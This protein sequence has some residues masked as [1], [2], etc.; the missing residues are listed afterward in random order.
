MKIGNGPIILPWDFSEVSE[1]ALLHAVSI[2]KKTGNEKLALFHAVRHTRQKDRV[3]SKLEE[4]AKAASEQH[5]MEV[6]AFVRIDHVPSSI[7]IGR[8]SCRERVCHRV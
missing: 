5:Q 2:G 4:R 1:D 3:L 8:A 7:E 6:G